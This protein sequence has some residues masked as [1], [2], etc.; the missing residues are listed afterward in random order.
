MQKRAKVWTGDLQVSHKKQLTID[1]QDTTQ[2]RQE[3]KRN[4]KKYPEKL[5]TSKDYRQ[6][7]YTGLVV[8]AFHVFIL[9]GQNMS[10][11]G[12]QGYTAPNYKYRGG[13]VVSSNRSPAEYVSLPTVELG[14]TDGARQTEKGINDCQVIII[15]KSAY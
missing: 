3:R 5:R 10:A 4:I 6:A 2:P 1:T 12:G 15:K 13:R 9:C 8:V 7:I 14:F 11:A